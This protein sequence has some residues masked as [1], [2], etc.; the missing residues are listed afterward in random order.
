V[1]GMEEHVFISHEFIR[2]RS[3]RRMVRMLDD[4]V[5]TKLWSASSE[6]LNYSNVGSVGLGLK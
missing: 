5:P 3:G 4:L 2:F 6:G 1:V